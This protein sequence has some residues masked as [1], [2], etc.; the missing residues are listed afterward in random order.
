MKIIVTF[1]KSKL[2]TVSIAYYNNKICN[3]QFGENLDVLTDNLLN[4]YPNAEI[5]M[6]SPNDCQRSSSLIKQIFSG[7]R[8]DE[9]ILFITGTE[10]QQK[11]WWALT[12]I[13]IGSTTTYSEIAER[14][15]SPGAVRAVGTA[16]KENP[17][18]MLVPCH[19]VVPKNQKKNALGN[20]RWGVERKRH[21]LILEGVTEY[22]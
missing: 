6:G 4:L 18:A 17:L 5:F 19:R 15:G 14:I 9:E 10:F 2:G 1:C 13:P 7:E 16:C 3:I 11:V 12:Q 22:D 20:Y 8:P 21:L